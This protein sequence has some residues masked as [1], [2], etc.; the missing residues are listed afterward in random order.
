MNEEAYIDKLMTLTN[1]SYEEAKDVLLQNNY[2][3]IDSL[4]FL[5]QSGRISSAD[6][7]SFNTK[8][9]KVDKQK[10][11][12]KQNYSE[13][14]KKKYYTFSDRINNIIDISNKNYFEVYISNS[15]PIK[16]SITWLMITIFLG[17]GIIAPLLFIAPAFGVSYRVIGEDF[18]DNSRINIEIKKYEALLKKHNKRGR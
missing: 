10:E 13:Y 11:Y 16:I 2:D 17:F 15:A 1:I 7:S 5:Q 12:V 9:Y 3:I 18:S 4:L 6:V 14:D 8:N